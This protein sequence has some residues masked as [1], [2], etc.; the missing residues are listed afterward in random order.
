MSNTLRTDVPDLVH[1]LTMCVIV[2]ERYKFMRAV[3]RVDWPL[4]GRTRIPAKIVLCNPSVNCVGDL[5][6]E[7]SCGWEDKLVA[8]S[9]TQSQ[10]VKVARMSTKEDVIARIECQ[11][12]VSIIPLDRPQE[13]S[14]C[15]SLMTT[16]FSILHR[17]V[18]FPT[19]EMNHGPSKRPAACLTVPSLLA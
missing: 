15:K 8:W 18:V 5:P 4:P 1:F 10:P 7:W 17:Y 12:N 14:K 13:S 19:I 9:K 16:H 2:S 6:L 11:Q 3:H